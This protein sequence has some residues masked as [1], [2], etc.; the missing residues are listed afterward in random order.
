MRELLCELEIPYLLRST[1]KA[2][3]QDLGPP[4]LRAT[5]FPTLPVAGRNR[6]ELLKRAGKVQV[7]YLVDPNTDTAMFESDAIREYLLATYA[8]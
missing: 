2:R 7:P 5:L 8:K 1:G 4:V 3:W 6:V